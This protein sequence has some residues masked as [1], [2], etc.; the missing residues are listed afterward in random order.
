A[1]LLAYLAC[2]AP[3]PQHR[4]KLATLLWG[5]HFDTQARQN[6][7]QALFRLR[8][9]LGQD[10]LL[11]DGEEVSLVPDNIVCD[12]T[13]LEV[14]VG[15][16]TG[17]PLSEAVELYKNQLLADIGIPEQA[18]NEWLDGERMRLE[19]LALD[20]MVKLG[21]LELQAGSS[22]QAL[23]TGNKAIAINNLRED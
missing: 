18:W 4:E 13:Q 3:I 23:A 8:R 19:G 15:Q 17:G 20:A 10:V 21:E 22:E 6:L 2:T 16:G 11:S 14:L 12:A 9:V 7:R 5:S 1:G